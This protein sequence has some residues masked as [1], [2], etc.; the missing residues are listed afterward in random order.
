[1]MPEPRH[2]IA[3]AVGTSVIVF[4]LDDNAMLD[5]TCVFSLDAES[6]QVWKHET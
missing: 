2:C 3:K 6:G 1:M 5:L 4:M